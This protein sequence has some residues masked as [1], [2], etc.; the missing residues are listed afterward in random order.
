MEAP[1]TV[2]HGH[3]MFGRDSRLHA[4]ASAHPVRFGVAV[5]ASMALVLAISL[6]GWT[7]HHPLKGAIGTLTAG[8][9]LGLVFGFGARGSRHASD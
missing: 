3:P 6:G 2:S 8:A 5:A 1:E 9:I 7:L 4:W